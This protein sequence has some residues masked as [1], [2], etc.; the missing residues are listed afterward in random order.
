MSHLKRKRKS[1]DKIDEKHR[2]KKKR[3]LN[4]SE[5]E[6]IKGEEKQKRIKRRVR[7]TKKS[8]S[9]KEESKNDLAPLPPLSTDVIVQRRNER[10][11]NKDKSTVINYSNF[12]YMEII[13]K[14][15]INHEYSWPFLYPVDPI[16]LGIPQYPDFIKNPMDLSTVLEKIKNKQYSNDDEFAND[17][18]QIWINAEIFNGEGTLI[19]QNAQV[20]KKDFE[21]MYSLMQAINSKETLS[22]KTELEKMIEAKKIDLESAKKELE[23]L[24]H[25]RN[26][27][28]IE[29]SFIPQ[30]KLSKIRSTSL[31]YEER[32]KLYDLFQ[33]IDPIF[34]RG[35]NNIIEEEMPRE[36]R[37]S[38]DEVLLNLDKIDNIALRKLESYVFECIGK[39]KESV[40]KQINPNPQPPK[41]PNIKEEIKNID[42][43]ILPEPKEESMNI[44]NNDTNHILE[45]DP[46][47]LDEESSASQSSS[48]ESEGSSSSSS[49]EEG[50]KLFITPL[51]K[52]EGK[53]L[54]NS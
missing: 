2:S 24:N 53:L 35:V 19:N 44:P 21:K 31:S 1:D 28:D 12:D 9:K 47:K 6:E 46:I 14:D 15:L 52:A 20:L 4:R 42:N 33:E 38:G 54:T 17:V 50:D 41:S 16:A 40:P 37:K 30:I 10:K 11:E 7:K 48:S 5:V 27:I 29:N 8:P 36:M 26:E 34:M 25:A 32:L 18:R 3:R 23:D 39:S 22:I 49:E 51:I 13:I 43:L 45:P